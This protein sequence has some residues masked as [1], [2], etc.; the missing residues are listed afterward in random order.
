MKY[1]GKF[2]FHLH[3]FSISCSNGHSRTE[4]KTRDISAEEKNGQITLSNKHTKSWG[5]NVVY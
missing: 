4:Y 5:R 1:Q 2:N 3:S